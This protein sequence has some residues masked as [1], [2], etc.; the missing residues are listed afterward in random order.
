MSNRAHCVVDLNDQLLDALGVLRHAFA[1]KVPMAGSLSA[2]L[3]RIR[4]DPMALKEV[5]LSLAANVHNAMPSGDDLLLETE[6][7]VISPGDAGAGLGLATG[8]YVCLT[9][10]ATGIKTEPEASLNADCS[11]GLH[12]DSVHAL[13]KRHGGIVSVCDEPGKA[14]SVRLYL[15]R[16][17]E[18]Y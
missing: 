7:V 12:L 18:K 16:A 2:R 1:E 11:M 14:T 8:E 15:P 3:W 17:P 13:A 6:N 5:I 4:V 9:V 10:S